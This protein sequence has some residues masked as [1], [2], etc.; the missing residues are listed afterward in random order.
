MVENALSNGFPRQDI[1]PMMT[2]ITTSEV[3][4]TVDMPPGEEI[5]LVF[6]FSK[7]EIGDI[8]RMGDRK[9]PVMP[10]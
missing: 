9:V 2:L 6:L 4:W 7:A 5:N 10:K 8:F 3:E 1:S